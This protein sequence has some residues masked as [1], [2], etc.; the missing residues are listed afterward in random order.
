[1]TDRIRVG[2]VGANAVRGWARGTHLPAL[3][4]SRDYEITA[5]AA[6]DPQ[7]A[8]A[9]WGAPLA[10]T[11]A[12][13]LA[14][15]ADVD[16]VVVAVPVPSR[17]GVVETAIAAG[18]YVYCEWPL[19][20]EAP[21]AAAL[22]DRAAAA[23]VRHVIGLQSR[24]HPALRHLR[25]LVADGWVGD[26]L[27]ASLSFT[28]ST[29]TTWPTRYAPLLAT[30]ATS[31]LIIVGGHAFDLF[32]RGVGDFVELSATVATRIPYA[33]LADTGERIPLTAP[34]QIAVHG[35]LASGAVGAV[36]IV[37]G[38]PHGSGYRVEVNGREGRLVMLSANDDLVGTQFTLYGSRGRAEP[39]PLPT[40]RHLTA[41]L[42][43]DATPAVRN[44]HRVY[45][46][47]AAAIRGGTP[48]EPD[49]DTAVE[50]H[51]LL[52]TVESS[53][54]LGRRLAPRRD[55]AFKEA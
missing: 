29:P 3:R 35:V 44:V 39:Q 5:I 31:R 22:R 10:F 47:L 48:V 16:L 9:V 14:A 37:T 7:Q 23:G 6:R 34:D 27:S 30:K 54:A 4:G 11:D 52:D 15:H 8:A 17:E 45:A 43:M 41:D 33:E 49:F 40:P 26:V 2:V 18:K 21:T 20:F 13:V 36:R 28:L 25:E 42:L 19:A 38:S 12:H 1:M 53:S 32:R 55:A 46:D 24:H 51:D 50:V